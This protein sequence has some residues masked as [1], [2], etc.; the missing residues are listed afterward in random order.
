MKAALKRVGTAM[1]SVLLSIAEGLR[2]PVIKVFGL[3]IVTV[4]AVIGILKTGI[5][6]VSIYLPPKLIERLD[7]IPR[8]PPETDL[9][10]DEPIVI[11]RSK[12]ASLPT[13]DDA[14]IA[15]ISPKGMAAVRFMLRFHSLRDAEKKKFAED[16]EGKTIDWELVVELEGRMESGHP[17]VLCAPLY[18][19]RWSEESGLIG[20][21]GDEKSED[22]ALS[23][24][25]DERINVR[26]KLD[27]RGVE[28]DTIEVRGATIERLKPSK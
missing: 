21:H 28:V 17:Y 3:V 18:F 26:G 1:N 20:V 12:P 22:V 4:C 6:P 13:P 23:V 24:G 16:N 7:R 14:A 8:V 10:V 19:N 27:L 5:V 25:M 11:R 2:H 9:S 15:T